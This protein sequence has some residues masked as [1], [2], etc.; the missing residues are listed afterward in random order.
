MQLVKILMSLLIMEGSHGGW[1]CW[2]HTENWERC[3]QRV[4]KAVEIAGS[5]S[6]AGGSLVEIS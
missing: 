3:K 5:G 6:V 2:P 1:A 4:A